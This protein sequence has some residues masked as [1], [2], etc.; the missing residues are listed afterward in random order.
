MRSAPANRDLMHPD[1]NLNLHLGN[2]WLC[3]AHCRLV[4]CILIPLPPQRLGHPSRDRRFAAHA[5][6]HLSIGENGYPHRAASVQPAPAAKIYSA[7]RTI[8][9][10]L[11]FGHSR[12]SMAP[13][14]GT[15]S[16]GSS[17]ASFNSTTF[18]VMI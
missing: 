2:H 9:G 8:D 17:G 5:P 16:C 4:F 6:A 15:S 7:W 1:T 10:G 18:A 11:I 14:G 12:R 13:C 3:S